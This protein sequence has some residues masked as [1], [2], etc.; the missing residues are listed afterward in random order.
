MELVRERII[1][2]RRFR[3]TELINHFP[4]VVAQ[5]CHG[6]PVV[7]KI[8]CQIDTKSTDIKSQ[9]KAQGV[10]FDIFAVA[11]WWRRRVCDE[12]WSSYITPK[13]KQQSIHWR[14]SG[15][16]SKT[17]FKLPSSARKVMCTVFWDRWGIILVDFPTRDETVNAQRYCE[18]LQNLRRTIQNKRRGVLCAGVVLLHDNARPHTARRTTH[19]QEFSWEMFDHPPY[20]RVS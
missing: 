12:T 19:L 5:N 7:Q 17:K 11:P 15:S 9:S 14:H 4:L 3:I 18:T 1:E 20:A 13:S 8:V 6:A 16:P 2:I 10:S